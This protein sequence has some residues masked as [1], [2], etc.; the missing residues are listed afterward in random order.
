MLQMQEAWTLGQKLPLHGQERHA[1]LD[2]EYGQYDY[3]DLY[4]LWHERPLWLGVPTLQEVMLD[5]D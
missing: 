5:Y 2:G 3:Q 4:S 1:N